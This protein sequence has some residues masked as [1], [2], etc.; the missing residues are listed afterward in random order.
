MWPTSTA[1]SGCGIGASE[2]GAY[3]KEPKERGW[4][5]KVAFSNGASDS[6]SEGEGT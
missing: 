4:I 3:E 2:I 6:E 1:H 5:F